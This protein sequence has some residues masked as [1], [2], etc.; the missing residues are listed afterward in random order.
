MAERAQGHRKQAATDDCTTE[1]EREARERRELEAQ[2]ASLKEELAEARQLALHDA[3]TGLPN[4]TLFLE[5]LEH[6]LRQARRHGW[7]L[8]V[9]FIDLDGFKRINDT[10]GHETGDEVLRA[11][12]K[13]LESAV[14]AED[15]MC[16][17]GGDEFAC[18]MLDVEAVGDVLDFADSLARR[19][20]TACD[21][22]ERVPTVSASI[23]VAL[24]PD[25]G[26]ASEA[27]LRHADTAMYQAKG[28]ARRVVF[29]EPECAD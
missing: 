15:T 11:V 20:A 13:C 17:Y 6:G 28:T 25:H 22:E 8:A 23:G 29:Y 21:Q 26:R 16:R 7:L 3:V 18:L 27:L 19:I 5:R 24:Y 14:R 4:R 1:L 10:H 2:V 12:A 9:L